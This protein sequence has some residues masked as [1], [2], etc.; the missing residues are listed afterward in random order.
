MD[1]PK[2]VESAVAALGTELEKLD[3]AFGATLARRFLSR[4]EVK[5]PNATAQNLNALAEWT[6]A[7]IVAAEA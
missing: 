2:L 7:A 3:R 5:V 4:N 6:A 1:T